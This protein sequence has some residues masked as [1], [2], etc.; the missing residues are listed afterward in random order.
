MKKIHIK[1][2]LLPAC[3]F[4]LI[5]ALIAVILTLINNSIGTK[6][7]DD[8]NIYQVAQDYILSNVTLHSIDAEDIDE[9]VTPEDF[10]V[11]SVFHPLGIYKKGNTYNVLLWAS[12]QSYYV[13]DKK[14][15]TS[16]SFSTAFLVNINDNVVVSAT[17]A[18]TDSD[19]KKLLSSE[20]YQTALTQGFYSDDSSEL[21]KQARTH[22][23]YL[24]EDSANSEN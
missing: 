4:V 19:I 12:V 18:I 5:C 21:Q 1:K 7:D 20:A 22:Y 24:S 14:L 23:T 6:V 8:E 2:E 9:T 17:K 15:E 10:Q 16:S 13:N 3:I 11:F